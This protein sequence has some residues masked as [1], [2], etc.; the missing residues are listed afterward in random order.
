MNTQIKELLSLYGITHAAIAT[1][2]KCSR[3]YVTMVLAGSVPDRR[4]VIK[5]A[6]DFIERARKEEQENRA[7][8]DALLQTTAA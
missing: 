8:L 6:L 1:K 3:P 7:R 2:A 5:T 4:G